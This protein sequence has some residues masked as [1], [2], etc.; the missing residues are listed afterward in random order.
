MFRYFYIPFLLLFFI[1]TTYS[2]SLQEYRRQVGR[3]IRDY[4]WS[5][6]LVLAKRGLERYPDDSALLVAAA[7]M[8]LL[9]GQ[10]DQGE[11]LIESVSKTPVTDPDL[12]GI[13]AELKLSQG[14][15]MG[16]QYFFERALTYAP[17]SSHLHHRLSRV[18]FARGEESALL[19]SG[20]A[21]ELDGNRTDYRHFYALMLEQAG[22]YEDAYEQLRRARMHTPGDARLL[23]RLSDTVMRNGR[24]AQALEYLEMAVEI[25]PESPLYLRELEKVCLALG[26][27]KQAKEAGARAN[28]L[29]L[30]FQ[31]YSE[32]LG[33]VS[34]GD[35][36]RATVILESAVQ[37][38]PEFTTG[39]LLLADLYRKGGENEKA[40][41]IFQSV[42][43]RD[44]SRARAR[45]EMAWL[46]VDRG[47][48]ETA[49]KILEETAAGDVNQVLLEG[50]RR[51]VGTDWE[52]A[53]TQFKKAEMRYPLNPRILQQISLCLSYLG[54]PAEALAY[55]EK[56]HSIDPENEEIGE[57]ARSIR[58][59]YGIEL[60]KQAKW[61]EA[62]AVFQKLREEEPGEAEIL[63]HEA[64]CLQNIWEYESAIELYEKGLRLDSQVPWV[65]INLATCLYALSR[66]DEA[67]RQWELLVEGSRKPEYLYH[68]GL[69]RIRQ[70]R[71]EE[72]WELVSQAAHAGFDPAQKLLSSR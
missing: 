39:A 37:G 53:M 72:G 47:D 36:Q 9:K 57:T 26:A 22:R 27:F 50:Y 60:E 8:M 24:M 58:L 64:Y 13:L 44:P 29:E 69:A 65:R 25:D 43:E 49:L 5:Q 31:A 38:N 16:A 19:Y 14:D 54:R 7:A 45:E 51:L 68:L 33:L 2:Q 23:L 42:L 28:R 52:G 18:L 41:V 21:V 17:K 48:L 32:A 55:L 6:A 62:L 10:P 30:A 4:D 70:W 35:D 46:Y 15:L 1:G 20:K 56:A 40:L 71:L 66:Y 63:F 59:D 3:L 34:K 67:A 11:I 12:L 61:K